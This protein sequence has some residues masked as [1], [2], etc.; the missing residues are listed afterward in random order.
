[1]IET[2]KGKDGKEIRLWIPN[3]EIEPGA[4]QQ[5]QECLYVP[6][7]QAVCAMPDVHFGMGSTVGSVIMTSGDMMPAAVGVDIGCGM[8][9]MPLGITD[10]TINT[11]DLREVRKKIESVIPCGVGKNRRDL[12]PGD[13]TKW[14]RETYDDVTCARSLENKHKNADDFKAM[15]LHQM[16]TLGSGNHFI[17]ICVEQPDSPGNPGE[18][19]LMIHSGSRGIG[20]AIAQHHIKQAQ[21][22]TQLRGDKLPNR[23]LSYFEIDST[24]WNHYWHDLQ[25]AQQ[26]A[27]NNRMCMLYDVWNAIT[28]FWQAMPNWDTQLVHCHH[29]YASVENHPDPEDGLNKSVFVIRK[30]A[31]RAGT[32]DWGII[33]GS[34]GAR[35]YIV[36]GKGNWNSF[37][38]AP[39]GA[40]RTMSRSQAKREISVSDLIAQTEALN[41]S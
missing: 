6:G 13:A 11:T 32:E 24:G 36:K 23:H 14:I 26:Y 35:S 12:L 21:I 4:L 25:W 15:T 7:V 1:M 22:A 41:K 37:C 31:I 20:L 9:A 18:V 29:N 8:L 16:G 30:G 17:E 28:E 3:H 38:S 5:L 34:M 19:W 10:E 40:G 2:L 39:H 27:W 33:P